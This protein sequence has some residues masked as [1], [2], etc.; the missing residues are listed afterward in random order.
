MAQVQNPIFLLPYQDRE[1]SRKLGGGGP[2]TPL[3][4][5]TDSLR[6][7]F[8]A[9]VEGLAAEAARIGAAPEN[10]LAVKIGLRPKALAKSNRPYDF[11]N[12]AALPVT[13]G[14][15][16]GELIVEGTSDRLRNLASSFLTATSKADTFAVS[17][18]ESIRAWDVTSDVFGLVSA[19]EVD[20]FLAEAGRSRLLLRLAFFP[21]IERPAFV[22]RQ[23]QVGPQ[24][25]IVPAPEHAIVRH[26]V[27][28]G[29]E[30]QEFRGAVTRPVV[31]VAATADLSLQSFVGVPGLRSVGVVPQ[32][33]AG[34]DYGPQ[35]F[36]VLRAVG[37]GDFVPAAPTSPIVGLL[38]TGVAAGELTSSLVAQEPYDPP[39]KQDNDHGTFVAGLLVSSRTLNDGSEMFP[40]DSSRVVDAQ[41]LPAG[42][43]DERSLFARVDEA[44]RKHTPLGVNVWNCSFG[45]SPTGSFRYSTL[46]Q[47]LDLLSDELGILFVVSS[48]NNPLVPPRPWPPLRGVDYGDGLKSPSEAMRVASVG[49]RSHLGGAAPVGAPA[50]Y[51]RR[52]PNFAAHVKPEV[53]HWA[54]DV[55][56]SG[57]L[58]GFGSRSLISGDRMAE[59]AGTSFAAPLVSTIAANVWKLVEESSSVSAVTPE[60]IRGL[61]VHSSRIVDPA[62]GNLRDYLGW[63]TPMSSGEILTDNPGR[64]TTVH[65]VVMT[66]GNDWFKRPFPVPAALLTPE[67]K[68]RGRATV[69]ISYA[70]PINPAFG[71]EA[72]R[73][74]VS[75][76]F[77]K[78]YRDR[79]GKEHFSAIAS[80]DGGRASYW[81]VDQVSDGK[82][83]P[84]KTTSSV[85]A[86]GVAGVDWALRLSLTERMANELQV[87]QL[88]YAIVTLESVDGNVNVYQDG[89]SAVVRLQYPRIPLL[90]S[91]TVQIRPGS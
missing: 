82:W 19:A 3:V 12:A 46:A 76:G 29:F 40:D 43:I 54:G 49:A 11:L 85:H 44:V 87:E 5:V 72:V 63:G 59:S 47:D 75:G 86:Q 80:A 65:E 2:K 67:G 42:S 48:G 41:V 45:A 17:T 61:L 6:T 55:G 28:R 13:A 34:D 24:Q 16:S 77:G 70:P 68:F 21:W 50:S 84:V 4:A 71:A 9:A 66:P 88:V 37:S 64:F 74:D 39:G 7:G 23:A 81:E 73:Y 32:Y 20:E 1:F 35:S 25:A 78:I 22:I 91:A 31:Y 26:L 52:G 60:L 79:D 53:S 51:S 38:D 62:A 15:G 57:G 36:E 8:A 56:L 33:S 10:P 30:V 18:F 89:V 83:S 27:A 58:E 90:P 69:T 14:E